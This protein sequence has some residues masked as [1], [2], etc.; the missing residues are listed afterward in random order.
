MS[1]R[2]WTESIGLVGVIVS[3][4]LL[5]WELNQA[6][7]LGRFSV[8]ADINRSYNELNLQIAS[9]ADFGE[10]AAVLADEQAVLS[11]AQ[12]QQAMALAYWSTNTWDSAELAYREGWISESQ[13]QGTLNDIP[14]TVAQLPALKPIL[15][16]VVRIDSADRPLS[17]VHRRILEVTGDG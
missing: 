8:G 14:A 12:V 2:S 17:T 6:N 1:V 10:F 15:R 11:K 4:G 7:S 9:D 16:E 13:F 5:T 3:M